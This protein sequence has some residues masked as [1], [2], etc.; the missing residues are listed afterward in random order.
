M[1][2]RLHEHVV[3]NELDMKSYKHS[4][5]VLELLPLDVR[6]ISTHK[7]VATNH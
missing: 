1:V 3:K 6:E 4:N 7:K 2:L 5:N